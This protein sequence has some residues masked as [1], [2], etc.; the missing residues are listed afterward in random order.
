MKDE[1]MMILAML[2]QG[3]IS[4]EEASMLIEALDESEIKAINIEKNTLPL[5]DN[6]ILEDNITINKEKLRKKT[7]NTGKNWEDNFE[8]NIEK[9]EKKMEA[10]GEKIEEKFGKDFGKKME[11]HGE[12][13]GMKMSKIGE[14]IAEGTLSF[15]D[16]IMD[17]VDNFIDKGTFTNLFGNYETI[18]E[19]IE[20]NI[21]SLENP[22]LEFQAINGK[23]SLKSWNNDNILIKVYCQLKKKD[24]DI[25]RSIYDVIEEGNKIIFKPLYTN[26]VGI[27]LEVNIPQE[28]YKKI[29]ATTTN[30][31]IQ[32]DNI[33]SESIIFNTT[34]SS[35]ILLN[36]TGDELDF[37]T[38]NG[39]IIVDDI[40]SETISLNTSN[41]TIDLD[42]IECTVI[43]A[44]TKNAKIIMNDITANKIYTKTSN[45]SINL[46]DCKAENIK[47]ITSNSKI[48][49]DDIDTSIL[50]NIFM[51]TSNSSIDV[52]FKDMNKTFNIDAS[53]TMGKLDVKIPNLVY[54]LNEQKELGSKKV[55]AHSVDYTDENGIKVVTSTSN[56]SIN[57]G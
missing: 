52:S 21:S 35:I 51:K 49:I 1:R 2:E 15:T 36:S 42:N 12:N 7:E 48:L 19:T 18:E 45:G 57:I 8:E 31:K 46:E 17:M 26:N 28:K 3:K 50:H 56:G 25:N 20:K 5:T 30:G 4:S 38:K 55:L 29:Q 22:E 40:T 47:A 10:F 43:D 16:K 23:I 27:K 44:V 9:F 6:K 14:N 34:N 11:A 24:L 33:T 13:F 53:T 39:K 37:K 54:E 41:A 32:A